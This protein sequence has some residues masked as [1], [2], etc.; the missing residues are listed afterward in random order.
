MKLEEIKKAVENGKRVFWKDENYE[1][2]KGKAGFLITCTANNF[3][4][5]LTHADGVTM[6]GDENDFFVEGEK[7][8]TVEAVE[9]VELTPDG[10]EF[11]ETLLFLASENEELEGKTIFDFSPAFK[12]STCNFCWNVRDEI[13]DGENGHALESELKK[14]ERNFG[15]NLLLS[16]S[17]HGC[18]FWDE[19]HADGDALHAFLFL[20]KAETY[21]DLDSQSKYFSYTFS[22]RSKNFR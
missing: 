3:A 1:V 16:L 14:C 18:G 21:N 12:K 8:E 22:A 9:R 15:G 20:L 2:V 7:P 10:A 17:G 5:G 6:N 19:T 13:G 11:L 4:I